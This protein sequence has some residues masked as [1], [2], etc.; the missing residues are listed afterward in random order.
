[1]FHFKLLI[2]FLSLSIAWSNWLAHPWSRPSDP[3]SSYVWGELRICA[4]SL[5]LLC[6]PAARHLLPLTTVSSGCYIC[7][8]VASIYFK[9]FMCFIHILQVFH[10]DIAFV[11]QWLQMYFPSVSDVGYKCFNC[12]RR[13]LQV[14]YLAIANVDLGVAHVAVGHPPVAAIGPAFMPVGVERGCSYWACLHARGCGEGATVWA[15]D[16][17]RVWA[18]MRAWDT[19]R[20]VPQ[21]RHETQSS[22]DPHMK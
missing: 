18:T 22:M 7:M 21:C 13:M 19:K 4:V 2:N 10:L 14:F 11:L 3:V 9:C 20:H 8:H 16:T 5:G 6:V 12:F 15:R 1:M 17:K